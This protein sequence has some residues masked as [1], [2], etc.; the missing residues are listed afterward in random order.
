MIHAKVY[1]ELRREP[2]CIKNKF[3]QNFSSLLFSSR[4]TPLT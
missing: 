2:I 4:I 3:F 1:A